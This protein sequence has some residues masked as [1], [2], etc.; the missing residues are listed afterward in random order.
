M[1]IDSRAKDLSGFLSN[2]SNYEK[3]WLWWAY[4]GELPAI[5]KYGDCDD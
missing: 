1:K 2:M 3:L 5:I 4:W